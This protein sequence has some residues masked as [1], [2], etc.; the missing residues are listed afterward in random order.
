MDDVMAPRV[1]GAGDGAAFRR[2][3]LGWLLVGLEDLG[4]EPERPW[5]G[6]GR[7][8]GVSGT[9]ALGFSGVLT[10]KR[11]RKLADPPLAKPWPQLDMLRLKF[12]SFHSAPAARKRPY[13][14]LVCASSAARMYQLLLAFAA[15]TRAVGSSA[16]VVPPALPCLMRSKA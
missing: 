16:S 8:G 15:S 12:A 13:Q 7:T 11:E 3:S 6:L 14:M 5:P 9:G 4:V 2:S 10:A 1:D